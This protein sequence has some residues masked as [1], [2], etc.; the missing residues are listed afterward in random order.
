MLDHRLVSSRRCRSD[1][2]QIRQESSEKR[3]STEIH[4]LKGWGTSS[5]AVGVGHE[6]EARLPQLVDLTLDRRVVRQI[7]TKKHT[8][9]LLDSG[10]V[11]R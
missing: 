10:V 8:L 2:S 5:A 11:Y 7:A 4:S 1:F 3:L 9:I 6:A